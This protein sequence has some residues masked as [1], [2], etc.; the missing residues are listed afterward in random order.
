MSSTA[1][2]ARTLF[3]KLWVR[4]VVHERDDGHTLVYIDRHY[5]GDDLPRD[6]FDLLARKNLRVRRPEATFAMA[7]H[8]ASSHGRSIADVVDADRRELVERLVHFSRTQHVTMFPLDDPRHGI[9]HVTGPE[10][11][12]TL[13]GMTVVCG[14]SHTSTHG[15]LGAFAFGIGASE[16]AHVLATQTLWQKRPATMRVH[17]VGECAFGVTAKDVAL[18]MIAQ[19][20]V[21]GGVG[22]V[23][24]YAGDAVAAMSME[25]RMTL[26]NLSIEAGARAGMIA[27]DDTAFDWL[28][29]RPHAP[30]GAAWDDALAAWRL[31]ASDVGARFARE[32]VIDAARIAPMVTWGTNPA[33]AA[34]IDGR[35]GDM[36]GDMRDRG[37][38]AQ[39][40]RIRQALDYMGIE[41][42]RPLEG[43]PVDRV[44]IGSC[45]NGRLEDLRA[46][47]AVLKGRRV[48]VPTLVVPGSRAVQNAA[49][50]EGLDRV[51]SEAGAEWGEPGCSMC[52]A[53][54]G[55]EGRPGERIASTT[56]RNFVGRQGR[57]VRTHLMS[58]GM[59]AGAAV[60]GRLI[61]YRELLRDA[62]IDAA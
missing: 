35:I 37:D 45:T 53:I 57:G 10:Q 48:R 40:E 8:Y 11:G 59:A 9:V 20:G 34:P 29:G 13:P 52:L 51:F 31:L 23:I 41:A 46:A 56:N 32:A 4:H 6:T 38:A 54:N 24:E 44:F 50:E 28:R 5:V 60:A 7:D 3:D 49:A 43:V 61:D 18:A 33:Q 21:A 17:I 55:D 58:P 42:G 39:R 1:P 62:S 27:P 14:D 15:A 16:V 22:H 2:A 36:I 26:C 30:Q 12:L 25:A 47:A 19:I